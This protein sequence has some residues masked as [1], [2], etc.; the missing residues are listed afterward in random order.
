M[1]R[2]PILIAVFI[3][4]VFFVSCNSGSTGLPIPKTAAILVHIDAKS[5]SSKLSW[6]EIKAS[7]WFKEAYK[8]S[9]EEKDSLQ[10]RIMDDPANS[11]LDIKSDFAFFMA[12]SGRNTL[13]VFEGNIKN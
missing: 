10:Q 11:G 6:N 8:K 9:V 5:L 7:E 13:V 4:A 3:A 12:P 2:L 1:K